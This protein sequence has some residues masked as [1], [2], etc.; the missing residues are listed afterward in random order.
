MSL[1]QGN[2]SLRRFLVFGQ[3]PTEDQ[4]QEGLRQDA[5]APFEDGLEEERSGWADWR[6]LLIAPPEEVWVV[7]ERFAHFVLRVDTRKVP[8]ALL[9]TQVELKLESLRTQEGLAFVGKEARISLQDEIKADLTRK[10]LPTP[11]TI[12]VAWDLRAG[13]LW[14]TATS[15][16]AVE[17][18]VCL[19]IKSFGLELQPLAPMML[20]ERVQSEVSMGTLL[21]LD[22]L[23]LTFEGVHVE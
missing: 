1:L 5:F 15:P 2:F 9:M 19:F 10:V 14:T 12:D 16:K 17:H 18:L 4:L 23:D 8:R 13:I 7:Q 11:K 21:A 20:A 22:P 6:N 3:V